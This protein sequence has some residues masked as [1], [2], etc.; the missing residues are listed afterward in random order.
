MHND[1]PIIRVQNVS[2][3]YP[4]LVRATTF[5]KAGMRLL[6]RLAEGTSQEE[7]DGF[8]ALKGISFEVR[9][10][11]AVGVVGRNGSGK[12]TLIRLLANIMSPT[13]GEVHVNGRFAALIGLGAGFIDEMTGWENVYLNA[14]IFGMRPETT[15]TIIEEIVNFAGMWKFIDQPIRVYSTGMRARL[16]FSVAVHILPDIIFIDEALAV[17][18]LA[19]RQ[20]CNRRIGDLLSEG[21]TFIIV[22]HGDNL[23]KLCERGLWLHEGHLQIDDKMET[24][25][26]EY[27]KFLK[28]SS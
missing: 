26:R 13:T 25:M 22:S 11:E 17:G 7:P 28:V 16:A 23:Q 8:T 12:T 4:R 1:S 3:V 14:A 6:E 9:R 19:F 24:V 27:R 5:R 18:D 10:G 2:K 15:D 21:R 20:K